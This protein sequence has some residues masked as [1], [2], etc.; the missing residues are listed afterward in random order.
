VALNGS[1]LDA[2]VD[3]LARECELDCAEFIAEI[4]MPGLD[5]SNSTNTTN[6][7]LN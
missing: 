4:D 7:T 6:S 2:E 3:I 5:L 1:G